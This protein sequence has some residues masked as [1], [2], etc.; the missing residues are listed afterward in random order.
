VTPFSPRL[1]GFVL[2]AFTNGSGVSPSDSGD[3]GLD[4]LPARE[5]EVLG[6][7]ARGHAYKSIA[8]E[9]NIAPQTVDSHVSS[10]RRKLQFSNWA[11]ERRFT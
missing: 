5:R 4:Q 3:P 10:V 1:A 11:N 7:I 9:R 6:L 8:N 2:E